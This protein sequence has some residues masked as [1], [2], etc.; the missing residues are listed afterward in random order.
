VHFG[1]KGVEQFPLEARAE[2]API[3]FTPDEWLDLAMFLRPHDDDDDMSVV[4]WA[5]EFSKGGDVRSVDL[6]NRMLD[7]FRA[8]FEYSSR[9]T[10]GTQRPGE[11]LRSRS[12]TCRDFAWLMIEAL[13]R[14]GF[15]ARFVS[16][17]LYD[18]ALDRQK[19]GFAGS[20]STHAWVQV[21]LPGAGWTH[22]DPTNRISAG[23]DLIPVAIARHPGQAIPLSGGWFGKAQDFLGMTVE[24]TVSKQTE[25]G[26]EAEVG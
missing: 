3:Q 13:R 5:R 19:E 23:F 18:V 1:A 22:Y 8:D 11:T 26:A 2:K 6:L 24:V 21:F 9:Q 4:K 12:G 10:E 15:A 16:G 14:S 7:S 20:G 25:E 17:Y